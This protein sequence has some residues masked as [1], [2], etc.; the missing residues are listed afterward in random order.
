MMQLIPVTAKRFGVKNVFDPKQNIEGGVK[1]L[2]FLSQKFP[3]NLGH[4]L[5]A[6]NAGENSVLR[7]G[8]IPPYRETQDY[9]KSIL[10]IYQLGNNARKGNVETAENEAE[11]GIAR[12]LDP[13]GR[14][15]YSNL[16]EAN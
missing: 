3:D 7:Y 14:V 4:V 5:A 10:R 11:K 8:G 15:V 12:Y 2:K 1:F 13:S 9:V 16:E 6:Y